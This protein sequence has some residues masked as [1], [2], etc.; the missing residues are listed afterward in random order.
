LRRRRLG[1]GAVWHQPCRLR[2]DH[3]QQHQ[4]GQLTSFNIT[5][6]PSLEASFATAAVKPL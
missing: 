6:L 4:A 1:G 2:C 3:D 5:S